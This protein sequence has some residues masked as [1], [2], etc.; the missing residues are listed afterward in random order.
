[1]IEQILDHANPRL[2]QIWETA[3]RAT[4]DFLSE[5]DFNFYKTNLPKYLKGVK[6]FGYRE[7]QTG[8][9][10]AFMG[11]VDK[12]L[13]MLFVDAASRGKGIGGQLVDF[14]LGSCGIDEVAVNEQ[15]EQAV[16]FYK[17]KGF[18]VVGRDALD[19]EGKPYPILYFKI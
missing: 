9:L 12:E 5:D 15:N 19:G 8:D 13:A 16:G 6:L 7:Q 14:A 2:L 10:V 1:M 17:R 4:H 11:I 3:V 18:V